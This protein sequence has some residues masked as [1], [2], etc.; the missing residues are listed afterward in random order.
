MCHLAGL[1]NQFDDLLSLSLVNRY[2]ERLLVRGGPEKGNR[3]VVANVC[4]R[5]RELRRLEKVDQLS[6]LSNWLEN[7]EELAHIRFFGEDQVLGFLRSEPG[8][9]GME[10]L[11]LK[12]ERIRFARMLVDSRLHLRVRELG[13]DA[14]LNRSRCDHPLP[15][16]GSG[17]R[18]SRSVFVDGRLQPK[19]NGRFVLAENRHEA[20]AVDD[21]DPAVQHVRHVAGFPVDR[22]DSCCGDLFSKILFLL[23]SR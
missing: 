21:G 17:T 2:L 10:S 12:L 15:L 9:D 5:I 13:E 6:R 1:H 23:L 4:P 7:E 8:F 18:D 3:Q 20:P 19:D 22:P 16:L 14:V 11:C